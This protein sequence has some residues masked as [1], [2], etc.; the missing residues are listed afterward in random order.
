MSFGAGIG[1]GMGAGIG[2]GIAIGVTEGKKHACQGIREYVREN[3]LTIHDRFG[4][5][6]DIETLLADTVVA[7]KC[8]GKK[9]FRVILIL[10]AILAGCVVLGAGAYFILN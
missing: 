3:E 10:L 5:E 8:C 4:N 7:K 6:V 1:A 9:N 2:T